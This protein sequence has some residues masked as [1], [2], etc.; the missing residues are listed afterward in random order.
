MADVRLSTPP[1][2]AV[3]PRLKTPDTKFDELGIYKADVSVPMSDAVGIMKTLA[4]IHKNHTGKV[5][6]KADNTMW[7]VETDDAGEET[8]NVIFKLRV[9]NRLNKQGELWDRRPKQFDAALKPVDVNPWGGTKMVVSF[10]VYEWT[11]GNK[12]GVSLQP[13][14]VQIIDLKSGSGGPDAANFGFA[15]QEGFVQAE[16]DGDEDA[17]EEEDYGFDTSDVPE[18]NDTVS[19]ADY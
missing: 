1:G 19:G 9:K 2:V 4:D 18:T 11:S 12:K 15:P 8:G 13:C 10:D 3:Y 17:D 14:A 16:D 7:T 6:P 5:P